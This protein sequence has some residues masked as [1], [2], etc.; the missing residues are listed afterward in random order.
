A[1]Q[2][3]QIGL[4]DYYIVWRGVVME[5]LMPFLH[6]MTCSLFDMVAMHYIQ[7]LVTDP[8]CI[9]PCAESCHY[10][11]DK[12]PLCRL[13]NVTACEFVS[14]PAYGVAQFPRLGIIVSL[15]VQL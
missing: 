14:K 1:C 10:Q 9:P 4:A 3:F 5:F 7:Y 11:A 6:K 12:L 13:I 8:L 15:P 2:E